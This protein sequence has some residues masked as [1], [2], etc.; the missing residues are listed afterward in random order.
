[1]QLAIVG[2]LGEILSNQHVMSQLNN[3]DGSSTETFD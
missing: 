2:S 1:M 3:L